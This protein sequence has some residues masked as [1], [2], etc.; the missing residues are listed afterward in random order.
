MLFA[1]LNRIIATVR[2]GT[3]L[4][5]YFSLSRS[6]SSLTTWFTVSVFNLQPIRTSRI[7]NNRA[8]FNSFNYMSSVEVHQAV[9]EFGAIN[10]QVHSWHTHEAVDRWYKTTELSFS[11]GYRNAVRQAEQDYSDR[12]NWD[13]LV[14][15]L[16]SFSKLVKFDYLV[17]GQ[18]FQFIAYQNEQD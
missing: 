14:L 5:C 2:T 15:L 11:R 6:S 16:Q 18:C 4:C 8:R 13:H 7:N 17:Y 9:N 3:I 12:Q 1:R 10:Q